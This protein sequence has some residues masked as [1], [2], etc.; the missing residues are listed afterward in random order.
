MLRADVASWIDERCKVT[1]PDMSTEVDYLFSVFQS[2]SAST[3]RGLVGSAYV[4]HFRRCLTDLGYEFTRCGPNGRYHCLGLAIAPAEESPDTD[5]NSIGEPVLPLA[6]LGEM[7]VWAAKI[8]ARDPDFVIGDN[9][10]H[11]WF[12]VPRNPWQNVYLHRILKSDDDRALH[13]HPWDNRTLVIVGRYIEHLA[14]GRQ[15]LRVAGDV[16]ERSADTLHRLEVLPGEGAVTLFMTGPKKREWGFACP[17]GWV[18]WEDFT[19]AGDPGQIGRG[20]G[21][22]GDRTVT[23]KPGEKPFDLKK[24]VKVKVTGDDISVSRAAADQETAR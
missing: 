14:D 9:Y 7:Q 1:S 4:R 13:D 21:E 15:V 8:V 2:W 19:A 17:Q 10:M 23:S 20:C 3:G 11:R 24:F 16:I 18:H 5:R 22:H 6:D 12:V